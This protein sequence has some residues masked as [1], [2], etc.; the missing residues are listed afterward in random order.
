KLNP[1]TSLFMSLSRMPPAVMLLIVLG[2]SVLVTM[3]VTGK[4]SESQDRYAQQKGDLAA[5]QDGSSIATKRAYCATT[6]I[7]QGC[8]IERKQI[9]EKNVNELE[10][11]DDAV[12]DV[13][14]IVGR[15]PKK[16]IP[17]NA[18]IRQGDLESISQ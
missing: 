14:S 15:K 12:P 11:W 10:V 4:V 7:P 13:T 8:S 3:I 2:F 17:L 1:F 16:D 6:L 18:Q 5:S 9:Q